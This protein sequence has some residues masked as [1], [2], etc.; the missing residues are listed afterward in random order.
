VVLHF[1]E[2]WFGVPG[3]G[4]GGAGK[5]QF[6]VDVE[7]SRKLTNYDIFAAAGGAMKAIQVSL[8][9]QVSDG[10]LNISFLTGA[11]NMPKISAIEVL[12]A[13]SSNRAPV[14]A[15]IGNK[16]ITLGQTLGFTAT[17]TDADAGQ[18]KTFS[19]IGAPQGATI[20]AT[21]GV[22][23]WKPV[24]AGNI[25]F[26]VKV[27]DN[28]S[29][30]LSDD[31]VITV[32]VLSA[33][34]IVR[35]NAGGGSFTASGN[36]QF[37]ADSYY[38]GTTSTL[39]IAA[40]DIVNTTDDALYYTERYAPSFAYNIPVSN[41]SYNVVLHFAE[42]WFGAPGG[43]TGG[44]GKRQFHVDVEGIR[45]LTNYDIFAAA[46]G[47]M[48]AIQVSLPVQVS[49]G[50]LNINFL[51]GAANMPKVSAIEVL[52]SS[53]SIARAGVEGT[54]EVAENFSLYPNPV[55]GRFTVDYNSS[56]SQRATI[57]IVNAQSKVVLQQ[58]ANLQSGSNL[59]H[60]DTE[61][62]KEGVYIIQISSQKQ[63]LV[64][65]LIVTN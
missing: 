15:T 22:F 2:I 51:T 35:L 12:P 10:T 57:R 65:K 18:T 62:M 20:N 53:G 56:S 28:G 38:N 23:S 42:I 13:T 50:T 9:V 49:D 8:P 46:G 32:S 63:T 37:I 6:H 25:T 17:A 39:S 19:L 33:G 61:K 29:P 41:G 34:S 47:A 24:Q 40:G 21:T 44:A 27:T 26:T 43:S 31:E 36:R 16:T 45:K 1:A 14:L 5:R 58:T 11:A 7:G 30:A 4:T 3:G 59:L 54:S 52:S 48:K 60:F 55:N 64:K